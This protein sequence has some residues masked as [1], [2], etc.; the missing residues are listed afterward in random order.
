MA[1]PGDDERQWLLI[2]GHFDR[3]AGRHVAG[4]ACDKANP[5]RRV[6]VRVLLDGVEQ[7]AIIADQHRPDLEDAGIGDGRHAFTLVLP[8]H[9]MDGKSHQLVVEAE[10]KPLLGTPVNVVLPNL[11]YAPLPPLSPAPP[12][13]LA[14]CAIAKDEAPYLLEWLAYHRVIGVD[15]MVIFDN[16]SSD[17]TSQMLARLSQQG[18]LTHVP[19]PDQPGRTPQEPAY[20]EGVQLLKGRAR[21]VAFIDLDEFILPLGADDINA[22]LADYQGVGG[23]MLPW[24]IFGSNGRREAGNGLVM[25][26]FIRRAPDQH[27][28]NAT[29]K[30]IARPELV[31]RVG[32]HTPGLSD[33]FLVDENFTVAGTHGDPDRHVVVG[34]RR[35]ALNHYFCKSWEEWGHKRNRGRATAMPGSPNHVR[36]DRDFHA[37]DVNDIEDTAILRFQGRVLAEMERLSALLQ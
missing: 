18:W 8:P 20:R 14:I 27:P 29:V 34:A 10:G 35:L 5:L 12:L 15:H 37:H 7:A 3:L 11:T 32:V 17:G 31:A 36:P 26:R 30:T 24:R 6:R 23:L 4:W 22:V 28:V 13:R 21:W 16:N 2:Y 25:Q 33:G 19:W 9:V 1:G